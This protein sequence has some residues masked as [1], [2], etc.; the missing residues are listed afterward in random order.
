[1]PPAAPDPMTTKSTSVVGLYLIIGHL[2]FGAHWALFAL[3]VVVAKW[4]FEIERIFV[5]DELPAHLVVVSAVHRTGQQAS[6]RVRPYR[7][8]EVRVLNSREQLNLL[9]GGQRGKTGSV[10][11]K[12]LRLCLK[13]FEPRSVNGLAVAEKG[14]QG[15][16][17]KV[18][19][20]VLRARPECRRWE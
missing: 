3:R 13:V 7:C 16:I 20:S 1:M 17:D 5:P 11:K 4:R 15:A 10:R 9:C 8:K 19:A 2:Q 6:D 18:N 14:C 12:F